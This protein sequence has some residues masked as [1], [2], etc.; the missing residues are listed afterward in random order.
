VIFKD[1]CKIAK[2][3]ILSHICR[4]NSPTKSEFKMI[5]R[6]ETVADVEAITEVTMAAFKN[7]PISKHTEQF[8]INA[9][10]DAN[11]LTIS[12][13]AEVDGRVVGHI[14]FSPV[15]ISDGIKDWYGLGPVSVLP[16]YQKQGIGK[17][18]I[19]EGLSL[20][21]DMGG[22]GCALVGDPNYYKRFGF[23]N[24][25]ELVHDGVPQEV[26]LALPF[27]EKVP[28]GTIV[29]HEGFLANG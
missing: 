10:R 23:K 3:L 2:V 18:L 24:Y 26:F 20:L 25:P 14:A 29:F 15:I 4:M 27:D 6:Q 7:H 11:A 28:Q 12:L 1:I 13:V 16:D 21:K 17:S 22:K 9:L 19:N 5:L 8:I